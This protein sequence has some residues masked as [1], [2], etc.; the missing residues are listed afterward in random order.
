MTRVWYCRNCGY[1]MRSRGRCHACRDQLVASALPELPAGSE[2]DEVGYR[3]EEWEDRDRGRLI[4]K[5]NDLAILHR[6]EE[7]ELVVG[8]DDESRVDDL[9][10]MVAASVPDEDSLVDDEYALDDLDGS[11]LLPSGP[12]SGSGS[13]S[14]DPGVAGTV[15]LLAD[16]AA[17]L[18]RDPTDMQADGD[19]AEASAVVFL[20]D[21]FGPLD[22]EEWLAV[23]RVTRSLLAYLGA[24]EALEE[25]IRREARILAKLLEP[26]S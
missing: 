19:V 2:D 21:R 25:E 10:A 8:A 6:F 26:V 13:A 17:R 15:R 5:L 3:L 24:D 9:V 23:G 22:E 1:E 20:V 12:G 11:G 7:D 14:V 4:E 18:S 16:A